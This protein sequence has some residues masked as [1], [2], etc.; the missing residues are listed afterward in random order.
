MPARVEIP[1]EDG[2]SVGRLKMME[3]TELC[4]VLDI[5]QRVGVV[6]LGSVKP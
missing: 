2:S 5:C 6:S 3:D 1:H 4:C